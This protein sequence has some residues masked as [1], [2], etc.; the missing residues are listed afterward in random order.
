M[1]QLKVS[2]VTMT[3][4]ILLYQNKISVW[5]SLSA[6]QRKVKNLNKSHLEDP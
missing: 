6:F 2:N 5:R 4:V 3:F 1:D